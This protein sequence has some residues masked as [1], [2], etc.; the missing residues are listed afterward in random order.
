MQDF[1]NGSA[2]A[3]NTDPQGLHI[4]LALFALAFALFLF[5]QISSLG[6]S[7]RGIRWQSE[8]LDRQITGLTESE[9]NFSQLLKQ[10]ESLVEQSQSIQSRYTEMFND[11]L[12][13]AET[14]ADANAVVEKYKIQ[15]RP[16][17]T[18]SNSTSSGTP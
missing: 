6:Q 1:E 17:Q 16:D 2:A 18:P 7:S 10:R 11:L 9:K 3:L 8:N 13:L 12:K 14:D 15:R 4:S 5:A